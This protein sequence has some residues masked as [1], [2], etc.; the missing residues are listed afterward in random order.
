MI[1]ADPVD[2]QYGSCFPNESK[3]IGGGTD[4]TDQNGIAAEMT[5]T[6]GVAHGPLDHSITL[7]GRDG[8][9]ELSRQRLQAIAPRLFG[10]TE[11]HEIP[12]TETGANAA[13]GRMWE[14]YARGILE[15]MPTRQT[16]ED[17]KRAVEIVQAAYRS[18]A[19][20][21]TIDLPLGID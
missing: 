12:L 11:L 16:G 8:Y 5:C 10:D 20:G 9:L 19:T 1:P 21:R 18:N 17:G 6:F 2:E 15:N 4:C 7:H 3:P 14:D 13:F